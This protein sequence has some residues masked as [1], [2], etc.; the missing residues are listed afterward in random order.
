WGPIQMYFR[1]APNDLAAIRA[2]Q[3]L[4]FSQE[5]RPGERPLPSEI[6]RG[7]L[8]SLR[9]ERI[10]RRDDGFG[11]TTDPTDPRGV[12]VT[13]VPEMRAQVKLSIQQTE[14]GQFTLE[15]LSGRFVHGTRE[16]GG[17]S[18]HGPLAIGKSQAVTALENTT[19]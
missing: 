1:L 6:A 4:V 9:E 13:A 3:W 19:A 14:L 7:V 11:M 17:F 10:I 16:L 12:P 8:Q 5:P 15:G 2:G 18:S